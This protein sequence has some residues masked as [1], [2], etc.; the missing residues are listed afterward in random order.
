MANPTHGGLA[1]AATAYLARSENAVQSFSA[2]QKEIDRQSICLIEWA[3]KNNAV[4]ADGYTSG[5]ERLETPTAEHE[6]FYRSSDKRALKQTYAGAFGIMHDAKGNHHAA[7][8]LFYLRRIALMNRIFA[9]DI[10]FEGILFGKS[11]LLGITGEQPCMV[12]SQPWH[13][14]A[15]AD[16]PHPTSKEIKEFMESLGFKEWARISNGWINSDQ[17][18]VVTDAR[19]DNFIKGSH[20]VIPIDLVI[21]ENKS[22][23]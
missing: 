4:L 11:L 17:A 13:R 15:N 20:G 6:V 23:L 7:T 2:D 3:R 18:I 14:A 21:S 8:P 22:L 1:Q 9:S 19:L 10:Q 16:E 5:L 12:I